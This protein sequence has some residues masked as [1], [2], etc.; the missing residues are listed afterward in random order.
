MTSMYGKSCSQDKI[1]EIKDGGIVVIE[2]RED[3]VLPLHHCVLEC[4]SEN[5][6]FTYIHYCLLRNP[7]LAA[8]TAVMGA[9][10]SGRHS[11]IYIS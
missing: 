6:C 4:T 1:Q 3:G 11:T 8:P 10:P 9:Q 7:V 5:I 2:D